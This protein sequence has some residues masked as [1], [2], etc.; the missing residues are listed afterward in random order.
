ML[1]GLMACVFG[2]LSAGRGDDYGSMKIV[3]VI[4]HLGSSIFGEA[5]AY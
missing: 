3:S 4:P 5:E 2:I 1:I